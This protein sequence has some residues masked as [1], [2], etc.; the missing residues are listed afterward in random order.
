MTNFSRQIFSGNQ[1]LEF[2]FDRISTG[3]GHK[4]HISVKKS[5]L[6]HHF[7]M[8]RAGVRWHI[9]LAPAPEQWILL[10]EKELETAILN[11]ETA[12]KV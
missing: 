9:A 3:S 1:P 4:Y 7:T 10:L 12:G 8:E 6:L 5:F 2:Y 11:H